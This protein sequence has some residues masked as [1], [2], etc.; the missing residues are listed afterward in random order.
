LLP[1]PGRTDSRIDFLSTVSALSINGDV[2]QNALSFPPTGVW[3]TWQDSVTP[4]TLQAGVNRIR[5]IRHDSGG[6][7][8]L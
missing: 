4:S 7:R 8:Q 3:T 6:L 5:I 1:R 2:V